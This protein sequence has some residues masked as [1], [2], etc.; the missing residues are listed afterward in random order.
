MK[1]LLFLLLPCLALSEVG[2]DFSECSQLGFFLNKDPPRFTPSLSS[3][4]HICQCLW[5]DDGQ[6]MYLYATLYNTDWKIPVYSAYVFGSANTGRCDPWYIEP[7]LDGGINAN[8]C[9]A[10]RG[11]NKDIGVKQAV[12]RDYKGSGYDRGHLYP[13]QHT[14]NHIS[15]LATSTLT[16]AAPQNSSF[17]Q[18]AWRVHEAAVITDLKKRD[19]HSCAYVVTGV[20]PD[21]NK[22]IPD[23]NP[24][25]TVSKYYWRATCCVKNGVPTGQGYFGPDNNDKVQAL[26]IAAL[27]TK[28]AKDYGVSIVIFP[29]LP[30]GAKRPAQGGCN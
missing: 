8:P 3:T 11:H 28:L 2:D 1:L 9:M 21:P 27:Q 29:S 23:N 30:P 13:V 26:S 15:M 22:K 10:P 24:R 18:G 25:V 19:K 7:Q 17:N 5:D 14:N 12:N 4:K 20:V 16:N 6:Q